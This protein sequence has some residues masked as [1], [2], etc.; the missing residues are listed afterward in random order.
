MVLFGAA[1]GGT[2]GREGDDGVGA[3]AAREQADYVGGGGAAADVAD[4]SATQGAVFGGQDSVFAVNSQFVLECNRTGN[5]GDVVL[6]KQAGTSEGSVSISGSTTS[7]NAF[8]GSHWSRL[9]DNSQPTILRGT[10][11]ETIDEMMD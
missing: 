3:A 8:T 4:G 7:Y 9:T 11:M 10:V 2:P 5:D 6:F 1:G